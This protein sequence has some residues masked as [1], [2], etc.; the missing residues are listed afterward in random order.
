MV[1][2]QRWF[3]NPTGTWRRI[4]E[5]GV[6]FSKEFLIVSGQEPGADGTAYGEFDKHFGFLVSLT[7]SQYYVLWYGRVDPSPTNTISGVSRSR[8]SSKAP[9]LVRLAPSLGNSV[10]PQASGS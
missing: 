4:G 7:L 5:S 1:R 6:A 8:I 2:D 3:S 10:A 9:S